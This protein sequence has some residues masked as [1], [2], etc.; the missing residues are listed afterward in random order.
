MI[1]LKDL[2]TLKINL[3]F[4]EII[5]FL[6]LNELNYYYFSKNFDFL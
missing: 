3:N 4:F 6:K 2:K 5:S 1:S